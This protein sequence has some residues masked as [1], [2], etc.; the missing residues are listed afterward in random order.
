MSFLAPQQPTP[1]PV[2]QQVE[3]DILAEPELERDVSEIDRI[4]RRQRQPSLIDLLSDGIQSPT[5]L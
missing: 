5:I 1:A 2:V 3:P 4:R